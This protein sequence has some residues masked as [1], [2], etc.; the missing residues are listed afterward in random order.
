[1]DNKAYLGGMLEL[2]SQPAFA[3][4]NGI[5]TEANEFARMLLITP[6]E[7]VAPL[8][9]EDGADYESFR[10]GCLC[11]TAH[12]GD[13]YYEA[14]IHQLDGRDIFT[15]TPGEDHADLQLLQIAASQLRNPLSDLIIYANQLDRESPLAMQIKRRL[16]QL[17]R[18]TFN[19]SDTIRY[20]NNRFVKPVFADA[21]DHIREWVERTE[22]LVSACGIKLEFSCPREP[23]CSVI[24]EEKLE[25]AIHN[26]I[27]NAMKASNKGDTIHVRLTHDGK[28]LRLYVR[29]QGTGIPS[30]VLSNIPWRFRRTPGL[31]PE[32]IGLG[33]TLV[34]DAARS[35]GGTLLVSPQ[36]N[37]GTLVCMSIAMQ[38]P[39]GD[40]MHSPICQFDY[41]GEQDHGLVEYA[42]LLPDEFY[43]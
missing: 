35:H 38:P 3:V 36:K 12:L 2:I 10:E 37:G 31:E 15:L 33:M 22:A 21:C 23:F 26:L 43:Q 41:A 34:W 28:R 40:R 17:Q 4:E 42:H 9:G 7:P 19:M 1:M 13:R 32:G 6:G 27:A 30:S 24:D 18:L 5:I 8:L 16:F 11:M 20:L 14:V 25:R 39:K 29:D